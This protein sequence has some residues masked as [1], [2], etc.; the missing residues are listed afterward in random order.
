MSGGW[1]DYNQSSQNWEKTNF[2]DAIPGGKQMPL[3][4]HLVTVESVEMKTSKAGKPYLWVTVVNG[5]NQSIKGAVSVLKYN[6][7]GEIEGRNWQLNAF[8]TA[9]IPSQDQRY[10]FVEATKKDSNKYTALAGC[11]VDV[12]IIEG[13]EGYSIIDGVVVNVADDSNMFGD[14]VFSGIKEA[15][16][17]VN[18][19][20][21]Q[22]PTKKMY[23]AW[24]QLDA[25]LMPK[26][27]ELNINAIN[28]IVGKAPVR[29]VAGGNAFTV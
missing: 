8:L 18:A 1:G 17:T 11:G 27:K 15:L 16:D 9:V 4:R 10:E 7:K 26:D 12:E 14:R 28:S 24:N 22:H 2:N 29:S 21:E 3:G 25:F 13:T 23:R 20:N 6:E 19:H 5:N